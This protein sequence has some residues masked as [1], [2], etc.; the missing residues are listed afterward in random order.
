MS[1]GGEVLTTISEEAVLRH[2]E[3]NTLRLISDTLNRMGG[4]M[5][6]LQDDVREVRESVIRIEAQE[7]K[8]QLIDLRA[9]L[10]AT[11]LRISE[12]EKERQQREGAVGF[13]GWLGK[14]L[15]WIAGIG[16]AVVAY[17]QIKQ[18]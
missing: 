12:L 5:Q 14:N 1:P 2:S 16:A 10:K 3:I 8:Q 6:T 4:T 11:N 15:P 9:D 18:G 7:V 13:V 17:F